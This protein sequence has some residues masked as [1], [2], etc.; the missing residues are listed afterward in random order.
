M[1][2][3][4]HHLALISHFYC[5]TDRRYVPG[6]NWSQSADSRQRLVGVWTQRLDHTIFAFITSYLQLQSVPNWV[7]IWLSELVKRKLIKMIE[8]LNA[9]S[10]DW[11]V[12]SLTMLCMSLLRRWQLFISLSTTLRMRITSWHDEMI[13][14]ASTFE[15]SIF[16][17]CQSREWR[18]ILL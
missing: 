3:I 14:N 6:W 16:A 2:Q 12:R 1:S 18:W 7:N 13:V 15:C 10:T 17:T 11:P 4:T 5:Q 8:G 9:M